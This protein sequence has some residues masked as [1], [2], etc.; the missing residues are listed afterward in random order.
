MKKIRNI[1]LILGLIILISTNSNAQYFY[2]SYGYA[3]DWYMP[4]HIEYSIQDN[5]YGYNVAHVQRYNQWGYTN[6]N[7][8]LHRNGIFVEVRFDRH[9][10]I[11]RTIRYNS[12][13]LMAHNCTNH[14]G[15]HQTYYRTYYPKYHHK[16]Y[17]Y[18]HHKT[19][20]VNTHHGHNKK[21]KTYYTNVHVE[22]QHKN[23]QGN[24]QG[25]RKQ[26]TN[27]QT[28]TSSQQQRTNGA[29]RKPPQSNRQN[30]RT[31]SNRTNNQT[32]RTNNVI[33][34][35][36][37]TNKKVEY[38]RPQSNTRSTQYTSTKRSSSSTRNSASARQVTYKNQRGKR[39]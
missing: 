16:Y 21:H 11:Y 12:Y 14:C 37:Q 18:K 7:V 24:Q 4:K 8:L 26:Q 9:G 38:K 20:Y 13:P 5:Y 17:G 15:Y 19:V 35:P 27:V 3:Q 10:H 32:Q 33:R 2:T 23:Y 36:Q 1:G 29:I 22:K 30:Q 31:V 25:N 39:N 6:F 28:R 34:K